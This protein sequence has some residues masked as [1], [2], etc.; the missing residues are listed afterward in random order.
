[1]NRKE[2]HESH[3]LVLACLVLYCLVLPWFGLSFLVMYCHLLFCPVLSLH[4]LSCLLLSSYLTSADLIWQ[5][6]NL[7]GHRF[8]T[9][10]TSVDVTQYS[11]FYVIYHDKVIIPW[12]IFLK[13]T[14]I[15]YTSSIERRKFYLE[16]I[17]TKMTESYSLCIWKWN[18]YCPNLYE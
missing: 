13:D 6:R 17:S 14:V 11:Y 5:A 7:H 8:S 1:M 3:R 9:R 10:S 4:V 2:F 18:H 16:N 15:W 12:Q